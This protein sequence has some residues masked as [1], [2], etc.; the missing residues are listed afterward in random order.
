M[1]LTSLVQ[2]QCVSWLPHHAPPCKCCPLPSSSSGG[3]GLVAGI[4]AYVKALKPHIK[5]IGVE[6]TGV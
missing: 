1:F 5:I 2:V 6:P 3:G 4:A